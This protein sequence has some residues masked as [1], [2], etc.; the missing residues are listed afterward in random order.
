[1]FEAIK[2]VATNIV[3]VDREGQGL[4][5]STFMYLEAGEM[6]NNHQKGQR[7][8]QWSRRK[9]N[10]NNNNNNKNS[11]KVNKGKAGDLFVPDP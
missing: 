1:M 5:T 10:N 8:G 7:S 11:E 2:V 3:N 6:K 9:N 4:T